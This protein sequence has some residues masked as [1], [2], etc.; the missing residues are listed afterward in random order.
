[1]LKYSVLL[2]DDEEEVT[3]AIKRKLDWEEMGYEEPSYARNGL[4]AL[5]AAENHVPD[6]VMTD[7]QMPYMT[8]LELSKR[9]KELYP[10]IRIII[11]SGYDEFEYAKEAIRLEAEEYI[12]K[13]IDSGELKSVFQRIHESLDKERDERQNLEKLK[14]YYMESLPLLQEDFFAALLDGNMEEKQIPKYLEEYSIDLSGPFFCVAILHISTSELPEGVSHVLLSVSVRRLAQERIDS[15]YNARF[16]SYHGS[17]VMIAQM[18]ATDEKTK[19]TDDCDRFCRLAKTVCKANVTIGIG[20]VVGQID[21]I[22]E[23]YSGAKDAVS[24]RVLYG[25][26]KAINIS[27]I[28]PAAQKED[29]D[30]EADLHAIFKNIK[31]EDEN[32]LCKTVE[33][34]INK[35][36]S[37]G[38]SVT[39]YKFFVLEMISEIYRFMR[40]NQ[41]NTEDIFGAE[42]D[43]YELLS[44]FDKTELMTWLKETCTK[45][46]SMLREKRTD[47]TKSF[48]KKAIDY[49]SDHYAD[50]DLSVD[51]ICSELSVS[52]AYFSTVFK[53]ETGKTFVTY[54]T[55][56]RMEKA[57]NLLIEK[58]EKTYVIAQQ[59][60]YGDPNYF[61][62][63]FKKQFGTSPSKYKQG[64]S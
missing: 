15:T 18:H 31:M 1:M 62:Y 6:V 48:V 60:G 47:N 40:G 4:E 25:T 41:L 12:L 57:L 38:M 22:K 61:S 43:A 14:S 50:Q 32:I 7:I 28:V 10:G 26:T 30:T 54:L 53:K 29:Y 42:N 17:T 20:E 51:R 9:L 58:D 37:E 55:D 36:T 52:S 13:P 11:F 2:V 33:S 35:G 44:Q 56:Y 21:D 59:V 8:G 23:S 46:Q 19:F 64:L 3:Q 49:V 63:V 27:E 24:Y 5:E 16:F 39:E 34:Y 45:L